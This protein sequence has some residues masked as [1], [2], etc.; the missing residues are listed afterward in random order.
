MRIKGFLLWAVAVIMAISLGFGA[1]ARSEPPSPGRADG[2]GAKL[3]E[4]E[5]LAEVNGTLITVGDLR[6][7]LEE[8][9]PQVRIRALEKKDKLLLELIENELLYQEAKKEGLDR[10]PSVRRRMENILKGLIVQEL[11]QRRVVASVRVTPEEVRDQYN[12]NK[13]RY[14][15]EESVT[16]SHI[17]VRTE[18]EARAVL[19]ELRSGRDFEAVAREKSI[20]STASSGGVLGTFT[21]GQMLPAFEKAAFSL[22]VGEISEPV[23]TRLGY[24]II[25]VTEHTE[26]LQLR[27][28]EVATEIEQELLQQKRGALFQK[29]LKELEERATIRIYRE[30]LEKL[31]GTP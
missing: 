28:E 24:H 8:L 12:E 14:R 30:R 3:S 29:I 27:F 26:P 5:I 11:L 21:S 1:G 10:L 13:E 15:Q 6:R 9:P 7:R 19:E 22:K 16:A 20:D 23:K 25:K 18:E 31:A 17:L 2:E 4:G